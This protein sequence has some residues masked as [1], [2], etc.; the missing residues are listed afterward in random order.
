VAASKH[1]E[2]GDELPRWSTRRRLM[3]RDS[4]VF[5]SLTLVTVALF[6]VTLFLFRSF[7]THRSDLGKRWSDRGAA[8]LRQG[9]PDQAIDALR[10]ALAYAP[11]ERS[12]ELLLAEA[13]EAAGHTEEAFNYFSGLWET[14]PGSGFINLQLARISAGKRDPQAAINF[15]RASIYGTW[16]GDGV[17]RRREV[18]LE[19]ARY[20]LARQDTAAA[21]AE[22][23]IAAGNA[24]TDTGTDMHLGDLFL[25]ADDRI[26]ALA[27][28]IRAG[29]AAPST[30]EPFAA[31]GKLAYRMG[32]FLTAQRL[33]QQALRVGDAQAGRN[34]HT[35][36]DRPEL[37]DLLGNTDRISALIPLR[38][39][40]SGQRVSRLLALST[41]ARERL[42][43]CAA[44]NPGGLPEPLQPLND[45]WS[46][47]SKTITR[48]AL[49]RDPARGDDLLQLVLN[50]EAAA[51]QVCQPATGDDALLLLLSRNLKSVDR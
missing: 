28:Y 25:Q 46:A 24:D 6:A 18:R 27:A 10:T 43:T 9:H 1:L 11:G 4:L 39:L 21:R 12:Y 35:L 19:L 32:E 34:L 16:E 31:A 13:L 23:L 44:A 36:V 20:L 7:A 29:D 17:V 47:I 49:A 38:K 40:S 33:L 48:S 14:E 45:R 3:L 22:L 30:P 15:Y 50:T 5:F 2:I 51:A 42:D 26:D 37:V 8:A 41:I